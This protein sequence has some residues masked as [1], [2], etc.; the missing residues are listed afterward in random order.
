MHENPQLQS[1]Q[2]RTELPATTERIDRNLDRDREERAQRD[3]P[4]RD[5]PSQESE[6]SKSIQAPDDLSAGT[7]RCNL[8]P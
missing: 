5:R 4:Q 1:L 7:K 8:S 3:L 2:Q 6:T